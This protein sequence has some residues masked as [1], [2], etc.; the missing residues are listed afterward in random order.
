M[1]K[2]KALGISTALTLGITTSISFAAASDY[3]AKAI[4]IVPKVTASTAN[5]QPKLLRRGSKI[6]QKEII[7]THESGA[8]KIRFTD[9]TIVSLAQNSQ[10][11]I[12]RYKF[13]KKATGNSALLKLKGSMKMVTGAVNKTAGSSLKVATSSC[14]A[15]IIGTTAR[16]DANPTTRGCGV[17]VMSG[18]ITVT[19][20]DQTVSLSGD[21]VNNALILRASG[22]TLMTGLAYE[23]ILNKGCQ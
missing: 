17:L 4:S 8:A 9:S 10:L 1:L 14:T 2:H 6:T 20:G 12:T 23:K 7:K 22:L 16:F 13:K 3:I 18:K 5:E 11:D 21:S 15:G 19:H